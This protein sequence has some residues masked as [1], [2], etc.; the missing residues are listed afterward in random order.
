MK[1]SRANVLKRKDRDIEIHYTYIRV[2][3]CEVD[4]CVILKVI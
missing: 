3:F 1:G 4:P 2:P